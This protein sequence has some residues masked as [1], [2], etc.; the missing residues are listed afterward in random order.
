MNIRTSVHK[1]LIEDFY[2]LFL[3]LL[4]RCLGIRSF[5]MHFELSEI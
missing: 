1:L 3:L 5:K 4:E 2:A